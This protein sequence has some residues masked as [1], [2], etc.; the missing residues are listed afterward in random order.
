[1]LVW[2]A[3][4]NGTEYRFTDFNTLQNWLSDYGEVDYIEVWENEE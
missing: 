1:M 3:K 2:I 4:W